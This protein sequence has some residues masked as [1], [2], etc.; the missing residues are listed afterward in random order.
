MALQ[1]VLDLR[2]A[3]RRIDRHRDAAG[4]QDAEEAEEVLDAGRQHDRHRAS[5]LEPALDEAGGDG[6]RGLVEL[7]VGDDALAAFLVLQHD[8]RAVG[9]PAHVPREHFRQRRR[10]VRRFRFHGERRDTL[11]RDGV[12]GVNGTGREHRAQ[13]IARRLGRPP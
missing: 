6:A 10:L 4:E 2:G 9:M 13:Q 7:G 5:R 1:V 8:V 12:R 11:D 3:R